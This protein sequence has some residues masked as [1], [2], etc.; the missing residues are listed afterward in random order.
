MLVV[1]LVAVT[2]AGAGQGVCA[3][4][5]PSSTAKPMRPS[6]SSWACSR[7]RHLTRS[8]VLLS[9]RTTPTGHPADV[10]CCITYE[11]LGNFLDVGYCWCN[12]L[13]CLPH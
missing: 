9:P 8:L 11:R 4:V 7:A 13:R 12:K 5:S 2:R 1:A 6:S 3:R 10:P